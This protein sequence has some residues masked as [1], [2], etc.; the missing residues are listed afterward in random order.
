MRP[1]NADALLCTDFDADSPGPD[2]WA[3]GN[4]FGFIRTVETAPAP[5]SAPQFMRISRNREV[6]N[7]DPV[8]A[9]LEGDAIDVGQSGGVEL[10]LVF[11]LPPD[12]ADVCGNRALRLFSFEY[13]SPVAGMPIVRIVGAVSESQILITSTDE[14]GE[15]TVLENSD[16]VHTPLVSGWRTLRVRL[17]TARAVGGA[18]VEVLGSSGLVEVTV[19][20][21]EPV[22]DGVDV[23]VGPS[24]EPGFEPPSGCSYDVDNIVLRA[25]P[26]E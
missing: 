5:F 18:A 26:L 10:D 9:L 1:E 24:F 4:A 15:T 8:Q 2:A 21:F 22:D 20:G 12:V 3:L 11:R 14:G 19:S 6:A 17:A 13:V 23:T 25:I 16:G 7:D